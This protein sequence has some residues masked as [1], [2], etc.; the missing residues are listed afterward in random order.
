MYDYYNPGAD[1][2]DR[3]EIPTAP[4]YTAVIRTDTYPPDPFRDLSDYPHVTLHDPD[5]LP[6]TTYRHPA[7]D[8]DSL[9]DALTDNYYGTDEYEDAADEYAA[10]NLS[11]DQVLASYLRQTAD[12]A[13]VCVYEWTGYMQSH[14]GT[15]ILSAT[16]EAGGPDGY[17]DPD[18]ALR[19]IA[20][21]QAAYYV[22]DVYGWTVLHP[23][24]SEGHSCGGYYGDDGLRQALADATDSAEYDYREACRRDTEA[25]QL[26]ARTP[27]AFYPCPVHPAP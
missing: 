4:G 20:D 3:R 24:G 5:D 19:A 17:T 13:Y 23:D 8:Y 12:A 11:D 26:T 21:A 10:A 16:A 9:R 14:Y 7:P 15:I 6:G 1:G 27:A 2:T 18:A 25:R 22:G